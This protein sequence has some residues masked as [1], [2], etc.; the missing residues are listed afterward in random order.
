MGWE[1]LA[2]IRGQLP[3]PRLML[4]LRH[5][6]WF[7]PQSITRLAGLDVGLVHIDLPAARS[8]PPREH[9]S[10]AP[11][12]YLRLHGRNRQTWFDSQAGRNARYDYRYDRSELDGIVARMGEIAAKT[13]ASVLVT[14]NHFEGQAVANALELKSLLTGQP[15]LAPEPLLN[16]FPDLRDLTRP[17]GQLS[18]F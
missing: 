10:L 14:N 4:E 3:D 18:L 11:L 1:R 17:E 5:R 9:A 6:S 13:E 16:A 8:H 7:T 15:P 12:G 2:R